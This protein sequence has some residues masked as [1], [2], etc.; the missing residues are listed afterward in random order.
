[1]ECIISR[2]NTSVE[3]LN[4]SA[5]Y[6][7]AW[8][9]SGGAMAPPVLPGLYWFSFFLNSHNEMYHIAAL[10]KISKECNLRNTNQKSRFL[11]QNHNSSAREYRASVRHSLNVCAAVP[12]ARIDAANHTTS[13]ILYRRDDSINS[14][15]IFQGI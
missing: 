6:N 8:Q 3:I 10:F 14:L 12:M 1:M 5:T 11:S 4:S 9:K 2:F 7:F 15:A 13:N